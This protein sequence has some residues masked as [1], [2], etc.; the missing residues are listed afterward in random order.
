MFLDFFI[1]R[2]HKYDLISIVESIKQFIPP[3]VSSSFQYEFVAFHL[4]L[5]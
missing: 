3:M 2:G 4:Q 1:L 5:G